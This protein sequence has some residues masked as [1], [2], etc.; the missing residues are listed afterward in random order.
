MRIR[1]VLNQEYSFKRFVYTKER[2]EQVNGKK[3]VVIDVKPRKNS[4]P[5]CSGCGHPGSTYDHLAERLFMHIPLWGFMVYLAY[6]MRRVSCDSCGIKVEQLPWASGKSRSTN[7]FKLYLSRWAKR[8]SWQEVSQV[9]KVSWD[10]VFDSVR[11]VVEYGLSCRD[12]CG[13]EAI[14]VD[15]I[16]YQKGHKYLTLV[17]QLDS[18]CRRLLY[19]TKDRTVDSLNQFFI[20]LGKARTD[21]IQYICSDMW[22]PY[23]KVI[24]EQ[25]PKA[26]HIL[27]RFHI[28][29]ML[30]K[31]V[32]EV[33]REEVN[34]LS[35][36]GYEPVLKKS[37]YC[38][39]KRPENLTIDQ[40][41]RLDELMQYDLKSIEAYLLKESFQGFWD[42]K[43]PYGANRYLRA[44][45]ETADASDLKPIK[46]FV[47]TVRKHSGLMMNWFKAKKAYSS[48]I[49]EGLNRRVN[50]VTRKSYGY[51]SFKTLEIALFHTMGEL[52]EPQITHGFS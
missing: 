4:N 8:L 12:L 10:T 35:K 34:R 52:S 31:A 13:I 6:V 40:Q 37:K 11:W 19:V 41:A 36:E 21:A 3:S 28:V 26:L 15:E 23:L 22:K 5:I 9:F 43:S 32:D 2:F 49:V 20:Q 29:A 25:A 47:K 51:R 48:G 17:Y 50:L 46:K 14:G 33:R 1:T 42:Y 18:G 44:W 38:F 30:N 45:C 7:A 16:Q 24:K 39:L 27:D